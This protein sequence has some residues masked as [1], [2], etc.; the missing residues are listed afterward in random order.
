M[1]GFSLSIP[2]TWWFYLLAFGLLFV[3]FGLLWLI[4]KYYFKRKNT[5]D[6]EKTSQ[7]TSIYVYLSL[8]ISA[9]MLIV[10]T[11]IDFVSKSVS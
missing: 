4:E 8:A 1:T 9:F 3:T 11:I 6:V 10:V 7:K 2:N 5:K